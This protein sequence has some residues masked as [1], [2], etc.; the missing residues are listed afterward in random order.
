MRRDNFS[1]Q[2]GVAQSEGNQASP[3]SVIELMG[4][5]PSLVE[6]RQIGQTFEIAH[7]RQIG[8]IRQIR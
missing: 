6:F 4:P 2:A 1:F 5:E 7:V 3:R 8:Q